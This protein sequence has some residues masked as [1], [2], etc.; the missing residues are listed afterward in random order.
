MVL[1]FLRFRQNISTL[2]NSRALL[3]MEIV[4]RSDTKEVKKGPHSEL[5]DQAI[6]TESWTAM[7]LFG[8]KRI[9]LKDPREESWEIISRN[10]H[11]KWNHPCREL[12]CPF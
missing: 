8:M 2:H 6:R 11:K 9:P 1:D 10:W 5:K 12:C 7:L 3:L 4:L